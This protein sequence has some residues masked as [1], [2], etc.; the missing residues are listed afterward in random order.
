VPI[1][2]KENAVANYTVVKT[3]M[4]EV[5]VDI[6]NVKDADEALKIAQQS[7]WDQLDGNDETYT[8][9]ERT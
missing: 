6:N 2:A 7:D 5:Q 9:I 1:L 4:Y 8:V 3:V